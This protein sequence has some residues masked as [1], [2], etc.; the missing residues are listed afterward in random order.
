MR[1]SPTLAVIA[2]GAAFSLTP[3]TA[4]AQDAHVKDPAGDSVSSVDV[5]AL[6]ARHNQHRVI[7][8]ATIPGLKPG[9]LSGTEVLIRTA[10]K[11]K[12]YAVTVL[13]S[14][15]GKV[16]VRDLSWRPIN[17]PVE[18][19]I[20]PC[21]GIRTSLTVQTVTVSVPKNCLTKTRANHR[22]KVKARTVD[23]TVD[24]GDTYFDDQTRFTPWLGR[25][26]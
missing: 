24:L 7:A 25:G 13:R 18:P 14:R 20:L 19:K 5:T 6:K 12:V 21:K 16:V 3:W 26:N 15:T 17:D 22:I 11:K 9:R 4:L 2:F 23:G 1:K 8:V 10:G